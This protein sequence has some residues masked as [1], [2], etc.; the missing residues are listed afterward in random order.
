MA[1]SETSERLLCGGIAGPTNHMAN[2]RKSTV[3]CRGIPYLRGFTKLC[4]S[5]SNDVH[6]C[7]PAASKCKRAST[8]ILELSYINNNTSIQICNSTRHVA[9]EGVMR[10]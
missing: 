6:I 3:G 5:T 2:R 7:F 8:L 4:T 10:L 9:Q 1:R